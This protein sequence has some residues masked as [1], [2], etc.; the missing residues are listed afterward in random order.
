MADADFMGGQIFHN[1]RASADDR[2]FADDHPGSDKY[3]RAEPDIS[4][5]HKRRG[6]EG[7]SP[8]GEIMRPG[9]EVAILAEVSTIFEADRGEV[10]EVDVWP[11]HAVR[12]Q[13]E[14]FR[15]CDFRSR[16]NHDGCSNIGAEAA[17]E[18]TAKTVQGARTPAE[19]GRLNQ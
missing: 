12:G 19:E 17:Q 11:D 16:E 5:N 3:V 8:L 6:A 4:A 1:D 14:I 2:E 15:E 10:V 13:R 7:H 9:A 18:P